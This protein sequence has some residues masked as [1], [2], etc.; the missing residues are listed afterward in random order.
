MVS[1][2]G[3]SGP[4]GK[5][6]NLETAPERDAAI[7]HNRAEALGGM[8]AERIQVKLSLTNREP[9]DMAY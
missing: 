9:E 5:C 1:M 6:P 8:V 4:T 7:L 3:S 2:V